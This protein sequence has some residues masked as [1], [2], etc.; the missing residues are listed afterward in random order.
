MENVHRDAKHEYLVNY[1]CVIQRKVAENNDR[2]DDT[3][4]TSPPRQFLDQIT[5]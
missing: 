1:I 3:H 2:V 5:I 4:L